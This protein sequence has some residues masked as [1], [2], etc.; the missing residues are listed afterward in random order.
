MKYF[1]FDLEFHVLPRVFMCGLG[2][3][4]NFRILFD[5]LLLALYRALCFCAILIFIESNQ[6]TNICTW[7]TLKRNNHCSCQLVR[8][9]GFAFRHLSE[10]CGSS[11]YQ[12]RAMLSKAK[13]C[14]FSFIHVLW[15]SMLKWS[16]FSG[17]LR[18]AIIIYQR[19]VVVC[20][21]GC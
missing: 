12:D 14:S 5:V 21:A 2:W 19:F 15:K 17:W 1:F 18:W 8:E 13:Y 11:D 16:S 9:D 20:K 10:H 7:L 4:F 3:C 6:M